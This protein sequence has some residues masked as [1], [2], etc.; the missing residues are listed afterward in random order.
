MIQWIKSFFE[1]GGPTSAKKF[2]LISGIVTTSA[3]ILALV[4]AK[5]RYVWMNGGD[6]SMELAALTVCLCSLAGVA[7]V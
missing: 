4:S 1:D 7:Y 5:A 3:S 2:G 6:I